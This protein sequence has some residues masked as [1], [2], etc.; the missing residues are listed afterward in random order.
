MYKPPESFERSR[1]SEKSDVW[2]LG[3]TIIEVPTGTIL[4][5][6]KR[7]NFIQVTI[8]VMVRLYFFV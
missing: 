1:P 4:A 7:G 5:I 6:I 3:M 8:L 2:A